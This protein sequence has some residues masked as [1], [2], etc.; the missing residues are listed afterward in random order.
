MN[1]FETPEGLNQKGPTARAFLGVG[2]NIRPEENILAAVE[3]VKA[4]PTTSRIR[5]S[6]FYRTPAL[7]PPGEPEG[8]RRQDADYLNGVLG[9]ETSLE[10]NELLRTLGGIETVLGRVRSEDKYSP[11]TMDLDLLLYLPSEEPG[12][13][14]S[15]PA[16]SSSAPHSEMPTAS[17]PLPDPEIR[18]RAFVAIPLLELAPDLKLP[19]DGTPLR[20]VASLF[21]G[22]GG[23][24]AFWLNER[25]RE[26]LSAP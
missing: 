15:E 14:G 22:V 19:P 12:S 4:L 5:A 9:I 10:P 16:S 23:E 13:G 7:S 25:L 11:R 20:D 26:L 3:I 1:A 18:T 8:H 6:S 21:P 17:I 2:S 24:K